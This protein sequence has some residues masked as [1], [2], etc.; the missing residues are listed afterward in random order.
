[1]CQGGGG[2]NDGREDLKASS[3][4][5]APRMSEQASSIAARAEELARS[6]FGFQVLRPDQKPIVERLLSG[7]NLLAVLP[8]G[9]GK[10]LCYQLAALMKDRPT[11][12]V[13]PLIA[14]MNDQVQGLEANG[15]RAAAIHSAKSRTEKVEAWRNYV[16]GALRLLY[17]SPELLMTDRMIAALKANPPG[18]VV[19]DEAH[20]VSKWGIAFRPDYDA[21]S[22]LKS[23]FPGTVICGFTATADTVTQRDIA[24]KLFDGDGDIVVSGFDRPNIHLAVRPAENLT[25]DIV[26]FVGNRPDASG[27]VYCA[28]RKGTDEMARSLCDSGIR[29]LPYHAGMNAEDR[30]RN[31]EAF[32]AESGAVMV[33]TIAFGMGIDKPDIRYVVH[34]NM[35]G[36]MEAYYQEI[37]RAGRD[38]AAAESLMFYSLGDIQMRRR[39]IEDEAKDREHG[40]LDHKRLDVLL[41]YCEATRC[42]RRM[43]LGYFGEEAEACAN[44]DVCDRPPVLVDGSREAKMLFSAILRTGSSFG[45]AHVIDVIR[46]SA[47]Q[48][49]TRNRHDALPTFGVGADRGRSWWQA[50]V[51]QAVAGGHV[52]IDIEKFGALRL[53]ES[54]QRI[55]RGEELFRFRDIPKG[56]PGGRRRPA[57]PGS[58]DGIDAALFEALKAARRDLA[59][60][61][62]VP[63]YVIFSDATLID[64]CRLRPESLEAMKM[65]NGVGP[66]KL[67]R[68]GAVLLE[69]IRSHG[70]A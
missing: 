31:A 34:A 54:G 53:T 52:A 67:D 48:K 12:V 9:A 16:S 33:A 15:V 59:Q 42:R 7:R 40:N 27:I 66:T 20:C 64:M 51:R 37:G 65:V 6:L 13:S 25:R 26:G 24:D 58:L 68:F 70:N 43:L 19:V 45:A 11:I 39:F 30:A 3:D 1:M 38:G 62:A 49:V 55:L 22:R 61:R 4:I 44:C 21:L 69:V 56:A 32:F 47:T 60:E 41:A 14:L 17:M 10:S 18:M 8:T 57:K 5:P 35:P 28:T 46:G 36:S 29:A 23:E 63:A 50:F 2:R